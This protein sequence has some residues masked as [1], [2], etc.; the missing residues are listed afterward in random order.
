MKLNGFQIVNTLLQ[1]LSLAKTIKQAGK[2][3][4]RNLKKDP[5]SLG[6]ALAPVPG[7]LPVGAG[8]HLSKSKSSRM[9]AM[10]V[11]RKLMNPSK[12]K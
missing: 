4:G 1:E 10:V 5:V 11:G 2:G 8:L 12:W 7:S 6:I 9:K 3:I